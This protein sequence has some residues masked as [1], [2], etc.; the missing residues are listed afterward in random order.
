MARTDG[1]DAGGDAD[2][3]VVGGGLAGYCAALEAAEAGASVVLCEREP[4]AGG[5]TVLSGGSFAFAGTDLQRSLGIA[6]DAGRLF[7][8][9]RRV[10]G[11]VNDPA[12]VRLYA[13]S[14]LESYDWLRRLG[15]TFDKVF[16]ASG[17]SVP[18]AHSRNPRQVLDTVIAAAQARGVR[19]RLRARVR[20]LLRRR[21][22]GPVA[23][24][25]V[26]TPQGRRELAA[27][28]VVLATGGFSRNDELLRLFAPAQAGAQRMGSDGNT[29]DGLLMAW[30]L[31]A[32][33]RDMGRIKGTF[34]SHPGAGAHDHF[35]LFPMYAG[36]IAV[37]VHARRFTDESQSYKLIGD[38]CLQQPRALAYQVFDSRIFAAGRPGIPAMDFQADLRAGRIVSAP[39]LA[40]LAR[41]LALDPRAL[42]DTVA[43]YNRDAL[44]GADARFGRASL[45]NGFG[46]LAAI[47]QAPF[48]AYPST[49]VVL[50]TYCGLAVDEGMRVLDVR[51]GPIGGLYAAGGVMGGFHGNAYMTGT[52]NGKATIFGRVAGRMAAAQ[53]GAALCAPRQ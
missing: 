29:G 20:R 44:A 2:V 25:A 39:T 8:D 38:A 13:D 40:G 3:I 34:G 41:L 45:C 10:G 36:A 17:Q 5:A 32:A 30:E 47:E 22:G 16:I 1:Q 15:V 14:Q 53:A 6:D 19:T 26:D 28:S 9:L 21:A 35:I 46:R 51:G 33:L 11:Y 37:N 31:G 4:Q 18:R 43:E 27:G 42:E 12:L 49:T 48:Y 50:A 52:A 24:V 7:D 23:G